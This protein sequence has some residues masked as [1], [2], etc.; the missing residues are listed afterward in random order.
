[1]YYYEGMSCPVCGRPFQPDDDVV[2]CPVCGLPHHRA[3]WKQE[4]HCHL[5]HLHGTAEQWS[6]EAAE[7]AVHQEPDSGDA[8]EVQIC[9]RCRAEN[10]EY[11]EFCC[12]C[13]CPLG[14]ADW[15]NSRSAAA[16]DFQQPPYSEYMPFRS[17]FSDTANCNPN[18]VIGDHKA[19]DL[20]AVI[21]GR[22]DY[23][24]PRFRRI[25]DGHSGGWNWSAFLLGPYWLL[26]RKMYLSGG[27]LLLLQFLQSSV[28]YWIMSKL[29]LTDNAALFRFLSRDFQSQQELYYYLAL[30][31]LSLLV[32]AIRFA[33]GGLGNRL[34]YRHS[35]GLIARKREQVPD[36]T[37][38]E[39]ASIGG[40]SFGILV[41]GYVSINVLSMLVQLLL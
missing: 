16:G 17:A 12:R 9:P 15:S 18:E 23:Y 6:R 39:L 38:A 14:E 21:G 7:A 11:A 31:L 22:T 40:T 26:Y 27:L 33:L 5:A 3:C 10:P 19:T 2:V 24:L 30:L 28:L 25:S 1:M 13:G 35:C 41:I 8:G 4:G 32:C 37:T 34:Y 29:N 20:A 36:I